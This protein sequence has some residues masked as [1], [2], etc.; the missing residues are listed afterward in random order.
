MAS[1]EGQAAR[2]APAFLEAAFA[3][4]V[5]HDGEGLIAGYSKRVFGTN[6]GN[7]MSAWLEQNGPAV[8]R[9]LMAWPALPAMAPLK[10]R[11]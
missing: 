7:E 5:L 2:T 11:R 4:V 1:A 6:A 3:R 9:E 8:E 10:A